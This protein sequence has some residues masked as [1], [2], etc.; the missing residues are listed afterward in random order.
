MKNFI[1]TIFFG[2]SVDSDKI[3]FTLM[4]FFANGENR[5]RDEILPFY[6]IILQTFMKL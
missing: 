5:K 6:K 1:E 2:F 4:M 3:S